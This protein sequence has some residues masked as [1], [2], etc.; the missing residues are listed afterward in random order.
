MFLF[1]TILVIASLTIIVGIIIIIIMAQQN[2]LL[3]KN[4]LNRTALYPTKETWA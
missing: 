3:Q 2:F 1:F 4:F